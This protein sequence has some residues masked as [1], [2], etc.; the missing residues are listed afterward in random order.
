LVIRANVAIAVADE[1]RDRIFEVAATCRAL[2]LDHTSTLTD[3]GVL[4]GSL[5]LDNLLRVRAVPGVVAVEIERDSRIK[6]A[7]EERYRHPQAAI[8]VR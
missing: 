2:G 3:I 7:L 5:E 8:K 1:A 6:E 4:L